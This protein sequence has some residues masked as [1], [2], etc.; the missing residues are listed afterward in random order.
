MFKTHL[1]VIFFFLC[2]ATSSYA[3]KKDMNIDLSNVTVKMLLSEIEK[4]TSYSF[5][6]DNADINE[7]KKISFK[8]QNQSNNQMLDQLA[9]LLNVTYQI[10]GKQVI[11]KKKSPNTFI[12]IT[13]HVTDSDNEP[14]IGVAIQQV[15]SSNGTISQLDGSFTLKIPD[16]SSFT[17]S[18]LGYITKTIQVKGKTNFAIR[19]DENSELLEEVVVVGYGSQKKVNLTGAVESVELT[20]A[21]GRAYTNASAMLQG[22]IAGAFI[23]QISGQP[24]NDD[25]KIQIRGIGTFNNTDPLVII[26]GMESSLGA[27][28]P[29]DIESVSVLKDAASSA[30][31]GNRAAN[32]VVLISTKSGALNKMNIEYNGLYGLQ[33]ATSLPN[34]LTGIDFLEM[35]AEA[36][37]NTNQV[38]PTWY[39]DAYMDNYRNHV[40][41]FMYPTHYSWL[42]ETYRTAQMTDHYLA[43]SGGNKSLKYATSAGYLFQDG[44]VKGNDSNKFTF[45]SNVTAFFFE[46]KL[47]VNASVS[48]QFKTINDLVDGANSAIYSSYV[49]PPTIRMIIPGIGYNNAGYSFG[50]RDA[51]GFNR[52]KETPLTL[53]ASVSLTPVKGWNVTVSGGLDRNFWENKNFKPTVQLFG[54]NDNGEV[55]TPQPRTS[56]LS[57]NSSTSQT[58]MLNAVTTY[59]TTIAKRHAVGIMAGYEMREFTYNSHSMSRKK[60][61]VNLPEFGVGD[62]DTQQNGS[63]A[64]DLAWMSYFGRLNY[65]FDSKYLLE[66]VLRND[67]S[68]RFIDKWG[69]FP[70]VSAAWR[71]TEEKFMKDFSWLNNLK[72]RLSWGR[73]GNESI[74]QSYA[75]SDELSLNGL[76]NF[77]NTLVGIAAVT[78]LANKKTSWETTEQYNIGLDIDVFNKVSATLEY[79]VK[80]T[81]DILMQVPVSSTLGMTTVPY[82]NAGKMR[83]KGIEL[84]L[85]YNDRFGDIGT[86]FSM[87]AAHIKNEVKNLAGKEELIMGNNIWR[88]GQPFN[89]YYGLQTEGIYQNQGEINNHLI[90]SN[91][92]TSVNPYMGMTP[93]PGDIRFKDQINMDTNGDGV[94]DSRDGVINTNDKVVLGQ[95]FPKWTF[96]ANLGFDWKGVDVSIFLQGVA[97]I[98]A[99]NQGIITVPFHGGEANTGAWY[100]DRWTPENP[101]QT[102][103]RLFSDPNRSEIVSSYYLEDASYLRCKS[104]DI[105]YTLPRSV[106]QNIFNANSSVRFYVSMQN[107]FTITR[108]RYGFDPEKPSSTTNTLQYPQSKIYSFGVN[109][110]F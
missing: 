63:S 102:V 89:S 108:M 74:G 42:D 30:I 1:L 106:L 80:N 61:T 105:G 25:A 45:R 18:Y 5:M 110:K 16:N 77:N 103:Q 56:E 36:Y 57:L 48:T 88:V 70:S 29:K 68:S 11:L 99:L 26:D 41:E 60:L 58:Y 95:S 59:N 101:S 7:Q 86:H 67:G 44:I 35:K 79:Y 24:G 82:Q 31:Y 66:F 13:G 19:L 9:E 97:G 85:R 52:T 23:S 51:G 8:V 38:W 90:F 76:M 72:V 84:I 15:N 32:G 14:I 46:E 71:I 33:K 109:L 65:S 37:R 22:N 91:Q 17:A 28:N 2:T 75:A 87:S 3:Q 64:Y 54:L 92:N 62:P 69:L 6:Y 43:I 27:V 40:D 100:K 107:L 81:S 47:K 20:K 94:L 4:S 93:V 73:L 53:N 96:S 21:K 34:I 39:T 10:K 12:T 83:N 104:L 49:A 98:K 78:K 55:S 50:A